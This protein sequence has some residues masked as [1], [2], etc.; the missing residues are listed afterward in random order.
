MADGDGRHEEARQ[1]RLRGEAA[2][3][4]ELAAEATR[5]A[6]TKSLA[7]SLYLEH[8]MAVQS[9]LSLK[10]EQDRAQGR[11][12]AAKATN[13]AIHHRDEVLVS[14]CDSSI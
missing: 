5:L 9:A 13:A 14:T 12:D 8:R 2:Q 1:K 4:A 10:A 11:L 7:E 3:A 6:V